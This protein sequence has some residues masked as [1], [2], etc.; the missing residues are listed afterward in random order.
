MPDGK[1]ESGISGSQELREWPE[2]IIEKELS[3]QIETDNGGFKRKVYR[4][5]DITFSFHGREELPI[6]PS[7]SDS[8]A[9]ALGE[10]PRLI[11]EDEYKDYLNATLDHEQGIPQHYAVTK[12]VLGVAELAIR[13]GSTDPLL[14]KIVED[15]KN[16]KYSPEVFELMDQLIACNFVRDNKIVNDPDLDAEALVLL[17]LLGNSKAKEEVELRVSQM[18]V[19][20][21]EQQTKYPYP[22][23]SEEAMAQY[24]DISE[25][26]LICVHSTNYKPRQD[27]NGNYYVITTSDALD[28][29]TVRN[30]VHVS[31]NHK[32]TAH[33]FGSWNNQP[34]IILSPFQE[35]LGSNGNVEIL[36]PVD[37]WWI[38]N[39]GESLKFPSA[40][41]IVAAGDLGDQLIIEE[42]NE[43]KVKSEGFTVKDIITLNQ[44]QVAEGKEYTLF[45]DL[46]KTLKEGFLSDIRK[47]S[48]TEEYSPYRET[49]EEL[50]KRLEN[51]LVVEEDD[52][53]VVSE[54]IS[55]LFSTALPALHTED[56]AWQTI[57]FSDIPSSI[58]GIDQELQNKLLEQV[59]GKLQESVKGC[60]YGVLNE[61]TVEKVIKEKGFKPTWGSGADRAPHL[62]RLE[63][64][65]QVYGGVHMESPNQVIETKYINAV[66]QAYTPE[67]GFRWE[68]YDI[69][70]VPFVSMYSGDPPDLLKE[71]P[72]KTRRSLYASGLLT[73]RMPQPKQKSA[74][75]FDDMVRKSF[76][77]SDLSD[78]E[79]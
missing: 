52:P 56:W 59:V 69:D 7:C 64:K 75:D 68:R 25:K 45:Y 48:E 78:T 22:F 76:D 11:N 35:M 20:D 26:D 77:D 28:G 44:T 32:V 67:L 19:L 63:N 79:K 16:K 30:S 17:G 74:F 24:E 1:S 38:R 13:L 71:L 15:L 72:M 53:Q 66:N 34:Y 39:P 4:Y 49:I 43:V 18:R 51:E 14:P 54:H 61:Y 3:P 12:T 23:R 65:L 10:P 6:Y 60:L 57:M 2:D 70:N 73:A 62:L 37:T 8:A 58:Q 33:F 46:N 55:K 41:L 29:A 42:G 31:L 21:E 36:N 27:E 50:C 47:L 5:Q 40:T 9:T